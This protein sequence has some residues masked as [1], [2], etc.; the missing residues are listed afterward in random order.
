MIMSL[1]RICTLFGLYSTTVT[2]QSNTS[3]NN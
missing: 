2:D 3:K 1:T